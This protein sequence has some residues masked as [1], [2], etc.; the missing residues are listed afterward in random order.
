MRST[1]ARDAA[2]GRP[3]IVHPRLVGGCQGSPTWLRPAGTASGDPPSATISTGSPSASSAD[4]SSV[5]YRR[6][7]AAGEVNARPSIPTRSLRTRLRDLHFQPFHRP[8]ESRAD[9]SDAVLD[10][11]VD[12]RTAEHHFVH[13]LALERLLEMVERPA[14]GHAHDPAV[15]LHRIVVNEA[16]RVHLPRGIRPHLAHDQPSVTTRPVHEDTAVPAV[17]RRRHQVHGP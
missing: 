11:A 8:L 15:R 14:D 12:L 5:T 7:P 1:P 17:S 10:A 4:P 13:G 2:R 6:T 3:A 16:D 9:L